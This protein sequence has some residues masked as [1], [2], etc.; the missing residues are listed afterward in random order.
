[1]TVTRFRG[2][3]QFGV[4]GGIG[5][6][7]AW[8]ATVTVL[9]ALWAAFDQRERTA[10]RFAPPVTAFSDLVARVATQAPRS[11]LVVFGLL[12]VV[13]V[14]PLGATCAI[15]SSTTSATCATGAASSRA[16][17]RWRRAGRSRSSAAR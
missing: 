8:L 6:V 13:S 4:I 12:T 3:S 16:R 11:C 9:P 5:M 17:P 2:F 1:M 10:R 7:A 14:V 15:R